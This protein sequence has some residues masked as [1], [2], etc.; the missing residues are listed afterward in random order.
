MEAKW[1][2]IPHEVGGELA[3]VNH[4]LP[5][6][7]SGRFSRG[8]V[9]HFFG[10]SLHTPIYLFIFC[11]SYFIPQLQHGQKVTDCYRN[12]SLITD[13]ACLDLSL[14]SIHFYYYNYTYIFKNITPWVAYRTSKTRGAFVMGMRNF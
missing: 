14:Q 7:T 10:C 11:F 4:N 13:K 12:N 6:G 9:K 8:K 2:Q 1:L 5:G 3:P